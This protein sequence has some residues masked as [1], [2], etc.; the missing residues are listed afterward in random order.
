MEAVLNSQWLT[1][2]GPLVLELEQRLTASLG[3]GHCTTFCNGTAALLT[4]LRGL[5][6]TGEVVTTPF[7]FPATTHAITW[8]RLTPVFCD[9]DPETYNLD[10]RAAAECIGP[11]TSAILPVHV[12]GN[13]CDVD[14]FDALARRHQLKLVYDAAHAFGV[15]L[16]GESLLS[17]GDVSCL[18][19]HATKVFHTVEGG[20]IAT[21]DRDLA[22]SF[23]LLRNFGIVD[24]NL[25]KGI[26]INGKM[27]ELHAAMGLLVFAGIEG[28]IEKRAALSARYHERL[29]GTEGLR[30]QR[31][32]PETKRNHFN[33]T[34]EIDPDA[35][36]LSRDAVFAGLRAE[37]IIAR[38]YFYPLCS[39]NEYYRDLPSARP[40]CLPVAHRVAARVLTLPL[41]GA[42]EPDDVDAVADAILRLRTF[43]PRVQRAVSKG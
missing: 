12:F 14:A 38:K 36:G 39:E 35:F 18:S 23:A 24:E 40:E 37:R 5:E 27:S 8:N 4:A 10:P 30:F 13:P 33:M 21:N 34:V 15:R 41:Y 16:R 26:G 25:V 31:I 20:A 19:F 42:L 22:A 1:N 43:A 32:E 9:I 17:W 29:Q 2:N 11:M 28:E 7:T 3:I 6:L